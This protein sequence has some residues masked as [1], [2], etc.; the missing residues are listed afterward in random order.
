MEKTRQGLRNLNSIGPKVNNRRREIP[1][2]QKEFFC[3]HEYCTD[4]YG[5]IVVCSL[6]GKTEDAGL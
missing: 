3:Q 2:G 5:Y 6:C 4:F 1:V